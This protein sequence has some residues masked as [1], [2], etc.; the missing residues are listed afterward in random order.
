MDGKTEDVF[1][2]KDELTEMGLGVPQ[3]V[4]FYLD[5]KEILEETDIDLENAFSHDMPV[6]YTHLTLPTICSV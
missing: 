1:V 5:L 3:A 4:E 2:R 6:S